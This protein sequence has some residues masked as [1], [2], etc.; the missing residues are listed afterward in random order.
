MRLKKNPFFENLG[1]RR[2]SRLVYYFRYDLRHV[3]GEL[4]LALVCT[5]GTTLTVLARPWPLKI[6]FDY[7]L[8]PKHR[9]RWALPFV[10]VKGYGPMGVATVSCALL[11]VIALLW[12]LFSYYQSYLLASAGQRLTYTVRRRF[13]AHLQRLS[14][15]VHTAHKTGDLVLRATGDTNMLREMLVDSALI[16]LSEFLVVF[17]MLGVMFY[18]DWQLTTV[19]LAVIPL[20]TLTAF[21]FSHELRE[22]VRL[23]RQRDGRMASLLSEVLHAITVVQAFGRQAHEDERFGEFNKRSLKLGLRAVRLEAGLERTVEVL[24]AIGTGGVVWFGV[25]RVLEGYL[26]PGDLLVFTGY[27]TGM[28]KPLRRVARLTARLSKATVCGERVADI[29]AIDERVKEHKG[30]PLAPAF[31]GEVSFHAV[32][33]HYRPD[34]AVLKNV[35]LRVQPGQLV[36]VVGPN[37]AGKSTLLGLVPR[38]YDPA[39][40]KI[41]IDGENIQDF[42]LDSLREQI[43]IVLQQPILFGA[44][45]RENIAYGKPDATMDEIVAVARAADIHDFIAGLPDGY[46]TI[47]AEGGATLSGGQRQKIAIAR[48]IIKDPPILLLD[49][50]TTSLDAESAAEVNTTLERLRRGKTAFRVAHRLDEVAGAD[51]IVVL[52]DGQIIEKGRHPELARAGGWYQ[53]IYDLQREARD[54][55][56]EAE[57]GHKTA[58]AEGS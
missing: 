26:T 3:R 44:S 1:W 54:G 6:V 51:L 58:A 29:L 19:S 45:I 24:V 46:E 39:E 10:D 9:S 23:Q 49:E 7:A 38:L 22:A 48:A 16:I 8:I 57:A 5:L 13:F 55:G 15:S 25:R 20:M 18:M 4:T 43:G 28:Y 40:G 37:G 17:A 11:L 41:R 32:H 14:L 31:A 2:L 50:P 34:R 52:Y 27:L 56:R 21:R 35:T 42:T 36:G 33:F 30:A 12:G 53:K 47:V